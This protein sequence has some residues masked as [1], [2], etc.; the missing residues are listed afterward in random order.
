VRRLRVA[1]Q[2]EP[3]SFSE[4]AVVGLLGSDAAGVPCRTFAEVGRTLRGG[5]AE[6]ALLPVENSL[7]GAVQESLDVVLG[8]GITVAAET[9]VPIRHC[10]MSLAGARLEKLHE[11][12]SHAVALGQCAD[13]FRARPGLRPVTVDDTAGAAREVRHRA[14]PRIAAIAPEGAARLHGLTVLARDVQDRPDNQTRF[15]LVG[16]SA[17]RTAELARSLARCRPAATPP[18]EGGPLEDGAVT[19]KAA[20]RL[21]PP[22]RPGVLGEAL[23]HFSGGGLDLSF[24]SARPTRGAPWRYR[25]YL[26]YVG[27]IDDGGVSDL[28]GGLAS[29]LGCAVLGVFAPAGAASE[30]TVRDLDTS[31]VGR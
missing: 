6:L 27:D 2:G 13:F 4:G 5:G 7:V 30:P 17:R 12:R 25:F 1:Y 21:H 15:L 22:P 29:E 16:E 8:D 10:L 24:L 28:A 20:V 3:G 9:V 26:E 23:A 11:V 31:A 18:S 19:W 14:D